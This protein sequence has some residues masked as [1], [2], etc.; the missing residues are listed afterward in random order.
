MKSI[1]NNGLIALHMVL[2]VLRGNDLVRSTV[3]VLGLH[4]GLL[5][6]PV[7]VFMKEVKEVSQ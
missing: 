6:D 3:G 1:N 7:Q 2:P 5:G 4:V